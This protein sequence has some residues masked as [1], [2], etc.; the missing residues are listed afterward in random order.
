MLSAAA[1]DTTATAATATTAAAAAVIAASSAVANQVPDGGDWK[2]LLDKSN[3]VSTK[4]RSYA[5]EMKSFPNYASRKATIRAN[6]EVFNKDIRFL[7]NTKTPVDIFLEQGSYL[8]S[9]GDLSRE[10]RPSVKAILTSIIWDLKDDEI[11]SITVKLV[12]DMVIRCDESKSSKTCVRPIVNIPAGFTF[13]MKSMGFPNSL[14]QMCCN[15][16]IP[17]C[18][19]TANVPKH[20]AHFAHPNMVHEKGIR[21][22]M[23][24]ESI[25]SAL[26]A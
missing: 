18:L 12:T 11:G 3:I 19:W 9:G 6:Q 14:L 22:E 7:I 15:M 17:W 10:T 23:P 26:E 4:D 16:A 5:S 21:L 20:M 2:S 13:E 8:V 25:L 24:L 1:P